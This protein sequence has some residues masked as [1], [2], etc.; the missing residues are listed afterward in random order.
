M[1][2]WPD[3]EPE[4]CP[5]FDPAEAPAVPAADPAVCSAAI[6]TGC[7][8]ERA[9]V[10][11]VLAGEEDGVALPLVHWSATL[12]ALVTLNV[13]PEL[14]ADPEFAVAVPPAALALALEPLAEDVALWSGVAAF[15]E[16]IPEF[17]PAPCCPVICT[18]LPINVR[19]AFRSPVSL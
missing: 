8:L 12:V 13:L 6:M 16:L 1:V 11:P 15:A 9:A 7:D 14:A 4:V 2:L 10:G 19:T 5:E 18:S 3:I 17:A